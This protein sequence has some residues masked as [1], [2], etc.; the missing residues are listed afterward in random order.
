M[1]RGFSAAMEMQGIYD[2]VGCCQLSVEGFVV[3]MPH[4]TVNVDL[5]MY[6]SLTISLKERMVMSCL[7]TSMS[8]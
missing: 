5:N 6:V 3:I 4:K 2:G 7:K 1:R 8:H